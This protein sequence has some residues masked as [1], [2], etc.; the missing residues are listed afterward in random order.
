MQDKTEKSDYDKFFN[1]TKKIFYRFSIGTILGLGL[2]WILTN[3]GHMPIMIYY[4]W[5]LR[6]IYVLC[7]NIIFFP[8]YH[9]SL[10]EN[11]SIL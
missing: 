1:N 2:N 8:V 5:P 9:N 7:P 11:I 6:L 4:R 3:L 10:R